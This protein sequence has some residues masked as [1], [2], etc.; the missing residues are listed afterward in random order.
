[1]IIFYKKDT[2]H[3]FSVVEGRYHPDAD[4][5]MVHVSDMTPDNIG[6]FV[7]PYKQKLKEVE[8]PV[9][10]IFLVDEKTNEVERRQVGVEKQM[11]YDG[12][13]PDI[14]CSDLILDFETKKEDIYNYRVIFDENKNTIDFEKIV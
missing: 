4:S 10:K 14:A 11:M 2:G 6:K 7:V 5:M 13:E 9:Y 1:M 12:L 8:V 3:I